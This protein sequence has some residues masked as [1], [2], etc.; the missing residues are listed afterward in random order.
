MILAGS[1]QDRAWPPGVRTGWMSLFE[2][3][4]RPCYRLDIFVRGAATSAG[5]RLEWRVDGLLPGGGLLTS[6]PA[7]AFSAPNRL[8]VFVPG[9][10][11]ALYRRL[12]D[13]W[14]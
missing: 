12:T 7:V 6:S 13:A 8:D 9:S 2:A 1:T 14:L 4:A 10:D 3:P 11:N 5:R